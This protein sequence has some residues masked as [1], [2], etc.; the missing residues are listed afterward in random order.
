LALER[1]VW[2]VGGVRRKAVC[3]PR[4]IGDAADL[5]RAFKRKGATSAVLT[6]IRLDQVRW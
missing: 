1:S 6:G 2:E 4:L 3:N 5:L